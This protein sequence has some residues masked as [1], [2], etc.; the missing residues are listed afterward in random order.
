MTWILAAVVIPTRAPNS[1]SSAELRHFLVSVCSR[2]LKIADR[3]DRDHFINQAR[4]TIGTTHLWL[5]TG[6]TE[7]S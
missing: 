7:S 6:G 4:R 5:Q 3:A 1:F 2:L